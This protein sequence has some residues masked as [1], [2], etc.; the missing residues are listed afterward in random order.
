MRIPQGYKKLQSFLTD[1]VDECNVSRNHR[2]NEAKYFRD[3]A[4][5][6]TNKG[7]SKVIFN[8]CF[9]YVDMLAST[10]FS[11]VDARFIIDYDHTIDEPSLDMAQTAARVL[12]R[13]MQ[14]TNTDSKFADG[15]FW[16][17]TYGSMFLRDNWGHYGAEPSL[18]LPTQMGVLT[19]NV[20]DL[21]RQEAFTITHYV[22]KGQFLRLIQGHPDEEALKRSVLASMAVTRRSDDFQ[23]SMMNQLILSGINNAVTTNTANNNTGSFVFGNAT[24]T[25]GADVLASMIKLDETWVM[26]LERNQDDSPSDWVTFLSVGEHIIEGR[27]KQRNLCGVKG[28]TGITQICPHPVEGYFWGRSELVSVVSIQDEFNGR[29]N[30]YTKVAKMRANPA[31]LAVGMSGLTSTKYDAANRPGG[32]LS[33]SSPG[34]KI[35]SLAP[36]MPQEQEYMMRQIDDYFDQAGG[37]T[38]QMQGK[39][40]QGVRSGNHS[41]SLIRTGSTRMRDKAIN[42]E[43]QYSEVGDFRLK[44][45]QVKSAYVYKTKK[46]DEFRLGDLPSDWRVSVDSHSSSPVFSEDNKQLALSL[47][48]LQVIDNVTAVKMLHPPMEDEIVDNIQR[49]EAAQQ[50]MQQEAI[51]QDPSLLSLMFGGK[52]KK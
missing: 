15:V 47:K 26:D 22:T 23:E 50:K 11:P 8:K 44:L 6:G 10:L 37:F 18:I 27:Y 3:Y 31:R 48:K 35:E 13:D 41:D 46:G 29:L 40:E 49:A 14:K 9:P 43:R 19:E 32:F 51:K 1:V 42:V 33:D 34:G 20:N 45:L 52:K 7:N 17:C 5:N 36:D 24:P 12:T 16:A 4:L 30:T 25:L 28:E 38:S 21:S 39:G 2:L